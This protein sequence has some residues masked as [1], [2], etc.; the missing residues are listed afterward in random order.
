VFETPET[1]TVYLDLD[2]AKD[3]LVGSDVKGK[4]PFKDIRVRKAV[5]I[6][7]DRDAIKT[8]TMRGF[9][10][11]NALIIGP[12]I[13][14]YDKALNVPPKHDVA[15]AKKL[16]TEAGYPN[17]FSVAMECSND[18]YVNDGQICQ[19][20]VGMLAQIG[21]KVNLSVM[22]FSQYVSRIS[23]PNYG[24]AS[25]AFVAWASTTYD[26][27]NALI[28]LAQTRDGKAVGLFNVHG[29]SFP[30][31][32]RLA[33]AVAAELDSA[34]R[35]KLLHES[36]AYIRDNVVKVGLHQQVVLWAAKDSVT[37]TQLA[38][39]IFPLRMVKVK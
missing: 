18:R 21:I 1:R 5:A 16:M 2:Q 20:V 37:L 35:T 36:F 3:E 9:S 26:G 14:G 32:D 30:E 11:P 15:A 25:I 38:D 6:A 31:L 19:A 13:N 23:P 28:N 34:K 33:N 22:P 27:H 24:V 8:K 4:N 39:N 10:L 29:N 12:G 17:G 7:I